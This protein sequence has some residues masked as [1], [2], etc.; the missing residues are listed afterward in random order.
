MPARP[1]MPTRSVEWSKE[2]IGSLAT[3]EVTQLRLNA[4]RLNDPDIIARCD[5]VLRE[6]KAAERAE[7]QKQKLAAKA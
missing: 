1:A 5:E 7:R 2:R 4:E 3:A 6:R